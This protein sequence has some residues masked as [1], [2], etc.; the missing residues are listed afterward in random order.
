MI[1]KIQANARMTIEQLRPLSKIDFGYNAES[2][3]WLEGYIERMRASGQFE[4]EATKDKLISVFGSFL[5]ECLVH[6]YG[7]AWTDVREGSW[8]VRIGNNF[9]FPFNKVTKQIDNGVEDGIYSFFRAIPFMFKDEI[10][11]P[12]SRPEPRKPWWRFW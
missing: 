7:G 3:K 2:V 5:G 9:A 12:P 1:D 8:S 4:N 10:K 11:L 6:C